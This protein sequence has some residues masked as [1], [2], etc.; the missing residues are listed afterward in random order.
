[1]AGGGTGTAVDLSTISL[2]DQGTALFNRVMTASS[3]G[4]TATLNFFLPK[5]LVIYEQLAPSD[6]DGL[7]HYSLLYLTGSSFEEARATA[8]QG[9][10]DTPD[11]LLLLAVAGE[12]S[13][14]LGEVERAREYYSH[15]LEVYDAEMAL[16]RPGY[17]HHQNI[18]PVYK[19]E[20]E[21][22]LNRE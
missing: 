6:P 17:E 21:A 12:A 15:F 5:A 3:M 8:E 4:D 2:D 22:F 16:L 20:A 7:Y 9:L 1:M 11:Y 10:A 14:G 19:A 18:F 13:A